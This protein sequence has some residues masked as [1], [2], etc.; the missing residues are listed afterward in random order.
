VRGENKR[1]LVE[2]QQVGGGGGLRLKLEATKLSIFGGLTASGKQ[3]FQQIGV[4]A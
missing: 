1:Y 3:L 2:E 4:Q